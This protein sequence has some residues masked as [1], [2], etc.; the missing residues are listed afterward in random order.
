MANYN[1]RAGS[2]A[3]PDP[4]QAPDAAPHEVAGGYGVTIRRVGHAVEIVLTSSSEYAS[5]ELYD[6]L[7]QSA[8]K[9]RLQL[10]LNLPRS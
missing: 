8:K 1:V 9:G 4:S 2:G 5:I 6:S 7:V 3:G 10:E